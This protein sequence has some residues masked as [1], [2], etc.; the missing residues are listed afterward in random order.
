MKSHGRS[1]AL[2]EAAL[3]LALLAAQPLA[4]CVNGSVASG[5]DS[6]GAPGS[7]SNPGSPGSPSNPG[8]PGDPTMPGPAPAVPGP[9]TKADPNAAGPMPLR[10]LTNREYNNTVRDLLGDTTSPANQF[11]ADRDETF[12]FPQAGTVA[13]Q[14]A[15]L[16][17]TAAETLAAAA[18]RKLPMLLPCDPVAMG[19]PACAKQ[20]VDGFGLRAFRRPLATAEADRLMALYTNARNTLKLGFADAIGVLIEAMLQAPAFL[21]HLEA[22]ATPPVREG[23]VLALGPYE[24]ASRLSYFI[25]GSMPDTALFTAAAGGKLK[26][27][28][29]LEAQA[30][31]LLADAKARDTLAA[32]FEGW[33]EIDDLRD[34]AKDPKLYPEYNDALKT[35][36]AGETRAFV[37]S[38]VFDGDGRWGTLLGASY[39]FVNQALGGLYGMPQVQGA[40]LVRADLNASQRAGFLTQASFLALTGSADGS[41]PVRRGKAIYTKLLC[42]ELPPPP[43]NVP[44]AKPASAGG[45]TRE[46][47]VEHDN[48]ECARAC[49]G[50]MDPIGFGFEA[51]DGIGKF[52]TM[53]NGKPVDSSGSITLD[54]ATKSFPGA[55]ALGGLLAASDEAR[56]CFA[57]Q[58]VRFALMRR[59]TT[60][61]LAS[62]QAAGTAFSRPE[63]AVRDLMVAIVKARSFRYRS[64]SPGETP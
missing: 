26:T 56:R 32:F 29:D 11:P 52:R 1:L 13:V 61:D 31:R 38:V 47:F 42:Q 55:V 43:A 57:A 34:K 19:E 7:P 41:N 25:W 6:P 18:V 50:L 59:E 23:A 2:R 8:S 4:G 33:L 48:N 10:R 15:K 17:R 51:Y 49:H 37:Q 12:L 30:R 21:Y 24:M 14:D 44:P 64:P 5:P 60:A 36:M 46:R 58:W 63:S 22:P 16:L 54:G 45:T 27:D 62:V 35:A 3:S 39:S 9:T 28:A 20:F 53:D 40:N